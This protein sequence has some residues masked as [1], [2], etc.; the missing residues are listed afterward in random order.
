MKKNI[1]M[2]CGLVVMVVMLC[3]CGTLNQRV[4]GD[5]LTKKNVDFALNM[6][7]TP[8]DFDM[9]LTYDGE[10]HYTD[11][12]ASNVMPLIPVLYWT[13][14]GSFREDADDEDTMDKYFAVR[15]VATIIPVFYL[16]RDSL[17]EADGKRRE[18]GFE[19][20]LLCAIWYE[21]F[22]NYDEEGWKFGLLWLPGLGPFFGFGSD[23]FQFLWIPFSDLD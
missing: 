17:Y 13:T 10:T 5:R 2:G 14:L 20:N 12:W 16:V 22:E 4:G 7:Q 21:D 11:K 9:R 18:T 3:S 23:Y 19:F 6:I 1:L 8:D 15:K